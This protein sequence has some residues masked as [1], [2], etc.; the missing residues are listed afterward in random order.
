MGDDPI[1]EVMTGSVP[2]ELLYRKTVYEII[3]PPPVFV[4]GLSA[5]EIPVGFPDGNRLRLEM[6]GAPGET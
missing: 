2:V 6:V 1:V 4:G 3:L 5:T